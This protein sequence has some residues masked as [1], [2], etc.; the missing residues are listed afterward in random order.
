VKLSLSN[1]AKDEVRI[2]RSCSQTFAGVADASTTAVLFSRSAKARY[3]SA[4]ELRYSLPL[5]SNLFLLS[6]V[7]RRSNAVSPQ[8]SRTTV[9]STE[10]SP[11]KTCRSSETSCGRVPSAAPYAA[12][13]RDQRSSTRVIEDSDLTLCKIYSAPSAR[14]AAKRTE[15]SSAL[16]PK[17]GS[18]IRSRSSFPMG[19]KPAGSTTR[20]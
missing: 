7:A 15:S 10:R 19:P 14:S 20:H 5:S 9:R 13:A 12:N 8:T 16:W 2:S 1:S 11:S 3:A 17:L 4:T 18:T 6:V